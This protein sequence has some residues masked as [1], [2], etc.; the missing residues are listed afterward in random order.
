MGSTV[1]RSLGQRVAAFRERVALTQG[2][3][4]RRI[5]VDSMAI[6]R[7]ERGITT[8][9]LR[10]L[11]EIADVLGVTLRDLFDFEGATVPKGAARGAAEAQIAGI[12]AALRGRPVDEIKRVAAVVKAMLK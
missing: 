2:E 4:A 8:P 10:R 12:V 9:S 7:L 5:G 3:L 11:A 1:E 6:S